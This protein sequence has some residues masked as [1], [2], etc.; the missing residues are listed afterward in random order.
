MKFKEV[1]GE[2]FSGAECYR[3]NSKRNEV[4]FE[5]QSAEFNAEK[6]FK[7]SDVLGTGTISIETE[8]RQG[9]YCET[10]SYAYGV[11][12]F[13]ARGVKFNEGN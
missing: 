9:G 10:C 11:M 12:V 3:E 4:T 7:L 13:T 1:V 8:T 2:I 5:V 6:L